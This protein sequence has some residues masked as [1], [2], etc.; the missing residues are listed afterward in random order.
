MGLYCDMMDMHLKLILKKVAY[1]I[2]CK[3]LSIIE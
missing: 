3:P 1:I 2:K